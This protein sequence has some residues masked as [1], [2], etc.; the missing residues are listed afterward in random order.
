MPTLSLPEILKVMFLLLVG[1]P[2]VSENVSIE[3]AARSPFKGLVPNEISMPSLMPSPSVSALYGLVP[4]PV[5]YTSDRP[6]PS[7]SAEVVTLTD[8]PTR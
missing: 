2:L 7:E 1:V 4:V 5:S 3:G 8:A 6:S